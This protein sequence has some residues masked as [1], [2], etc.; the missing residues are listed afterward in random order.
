MIGTPARVAMRLERAQ[1]LLDAPG[2]PT[3]LV[4]RVI[5]LGALALQAADYRL[6]HESN[7]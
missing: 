4:R 2:E 6:E 7:H 5:D 1:R 3:A